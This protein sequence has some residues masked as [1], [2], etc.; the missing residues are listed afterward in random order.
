[1]KSEFKLSPLTEVRLPEDVLAHFAA[2]FVRIC[3]LIYLVPVAISIYRDTLVEPTPLAI[4]IVAIYGLTALLAWR[5]H[6]L[7]T[8][9]QIG[10]MILLLCL[11]SVA[12]TV[13][14]ESIMSAS[15][16]VLFA[17]IA[18]MMLYGLRWA[19]AGSLLFLSAL[20]ALYLSFEPPNLMYG[21]IHMGLAVGIQTGLLI[22]INAIWNVFVS[23]RHR[24]EQ[25][26][27]LT[28]IAS[29]QSR[30]GLFRHDQQSD[31]WKVNEVYRQMYGIGHDEQIHGREHVLAAADPRDIPHLVEKFK[32]GLA[33]GDSMSFVHRLTG[34]LGPRWVRVNIN[35]LQEEG[36]PVAYGSIIDIHEHKLR[37]NELDQVHQQN[38]EL[39]EHLTLATEEADIRI[40]EENLTQGTARFLARGKSPR[41]EAPTY[42]DRLHIV[43]PNYRGALDHAYTEP[44]NVAEY[45]II[46]KKY[47]T[48]TEWLRQRYVR[49]IERDGDEIALFMVMGITQEK[50][51][52]LQLQRSLQQ[53]EESLARQDEIAKAGEIGLFEWAVDSDIVRSNTIFREQ[54]GLDEERFPLLTVKNL[55]ELFNDEEG[56]VFLHQM[57]SA[58]TAEGSFEFQI[59]IKSDND[60]SRWLRITASAHETEGAGK[61]IYASLVDLTEHLA[62]E[63][64]LREANLRLQQQSRTDPLTKLANRREMDEYMKSQLNLRHR[65]P[66]SSFTLVMADIDYFKAY[67]DTYGH[68]VGDKALQQVA[69]LLTDIARR[70]ADLVTRFGGEEF[71]LILP[72]TDTAGAKLLCGQIREALAL[73]AIEH[74]ESP[75]GQLTVSLGITTLKRMELA[76]AQELIDA[77]DNALYSAKENGRNRTEYKAVSELI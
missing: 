32:K 38:N 65:D 17:S 10:T 2:L 67:N 3:L 24:L 50:K 77:A 45:P 37:Q 27:R 53:V 58:S 11:G 44:G 42:E 5:Q 70:P 16:T 75:L 72:D 59:E 40:I 14:N 8:R 43:D 56:Q 60:T 12:V 35:M 39:L 9:A 48:G 25:T 31:T 51:S 28:E 15:T 18:T 62:L 23:S 57:R 61:R 33:V 66:A 76:T 7:G 73:A 49:K 29:T 1:M 21:I 30:I 64:Q 26:L 55:T 4:P 41:P 22:A 36:H 20:F 54:T 6:L 34:D 71:I 63:Q 52:R 69:R 68:L 19:I 47:V 46:G 13:R 74:S